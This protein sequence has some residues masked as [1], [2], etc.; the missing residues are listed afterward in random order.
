[1]PSDKFP[2]GFINYPTPV[3]HDVPYQARPSPKNPVVKG[4][5]LHYLSS[6]VS[7]ISPLHSF[8]WNNAGF[9]AL[10][11][12][13]ELEDIEARYDPTV[14]LLPKPG[15]EA[16]VS[17]TSGADLRVPPREWNGRFYTIADLHDAYK[18]GKVTPSDVVEVLLPLIRRDLEKRSPHSTAFVHIR[19]ELMREAAEA[20]TRRYQEGKPLGVL[21]GVPFAVK[22]HVE[23]KGYKRYAGT[24]YDYTKGKEVETSWCVKKIEEEGGVMI[25]KTSMHELGLDTTNN[26]LHWGTPLNPYNEEYYCGGSS[27]GSA[28]AVAQ[29]LVAFA[30]GTD[31]GGSI[32]IPSNYCGVYGLKPSHGRVSQAPLSIPAISTAVTGPIASNMVDL[33]V[34]YRVLAQPDPSHLSSRQFALPKP[35]S[36]PRSK[37][38]GIFR[39]LFDRADPPVKELCQNALDYLAKSGYQIIDITLPLIPEGQLAHA[40]TILSE[41]ATAHDDVTGFSPANKVLLKVAAQTPA[42]DFLLSQRL[43]NMLMQHLAYLFQTHPGLI[44]VTP[45]T[46]NAGWPIGSGELAYGMSDGN[47]QIR[48]MEYVWLANFTG[49]PC[50]QFPVGYVDG[51]QGKSRVPVGLSGNGEWGAEDELIE[52]GYDGEQWLNEGFDGGRVRPKEWVD[53]LGKSE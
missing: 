48:N 20:S 40:M 24:K 43:R 7:A 32:R 42:R 37:K 3:L 23:V 49:I 36:T 39:T 5:I 12:K 2:I 15:D 8:L 38:L 34:S 46:P 52:F 33:E 27:G 1:M 31:G 51:K 17:Y 10:R 26:N 4:L 44:I 30:V 6:I 22:D 45:T 35:I 41:G 21:D 19:P 25:G 29:G 13:K 50:I 18:S 47:T 9:N 16:I 14:I 53:V 11:D 28:Y